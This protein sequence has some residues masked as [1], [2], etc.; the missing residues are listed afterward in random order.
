[1]DRRTFI[2]TGTWPRDIAPARPA[3]AGGGQEADCILVRIGD[4]GQSEA[5]EGSA[6]RSVQCRP[7]GIRAQHRLPRL[8]TRQAAP[9]RHAFG[10]RPRHRLHRR[11]E[12]RRHDGGGRPTAG[13][14]RLR[15]RSSAGTTGC[16]PCSSISA[17]TT[18]S[19]M[20]LP[21][22]TRRWGCSTTRPCS[23][24]K[25]GQPPTTI[26]ELETLA[27][28]MKAEGLV[29]F[30]AGNADW[31]GANEWHVSI[32]LNSIAGP[33]SR[34]QGADRR[35]AV[36]GRSDRQ[37]DRYAERVV[38]EGL[39]RPELLLADPRAGFRPAADRAGR[40][41]ADRHLELHQ[42][43]RGFPA[44]QRPAGLRGLPQRRRRAQ[45]DLRARHRLDLLDQRRV[46]GRRR[47]RGRVRHDLH[48]EVLQRHELGLAGRVEPA[49]EGPVAGEAR[50][51]RD[52]ALHRDHEEPGRRRSPTTSTATRPGRSCRRRPTPTS[53]AASRRCGSA[54][55]RPRT[56]SRSGTTPSSRKRRRARFRRCRR[57]P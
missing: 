7:P 35:D 24:R 9:G 36:D 52:A 48:A 42:R 55:P 51:Q 27:D 6:R 2:K 11:A 53:S 13:A 20:R 14:R 43:R 15:A 37:G 19:S 3:R 1:M 50:G 5:P 17:S 25:A 54:R 41:G 10:Q 56:T 4:A 18:A 26:A 16:C 46:A 38:A 23:P 40:H 29:P 31:R 12:L 49:A 45:S 32:V 34:L 33:D 44:D 39:F 57:G 22:P 28:T 47:R 30:A 21:R 8:R